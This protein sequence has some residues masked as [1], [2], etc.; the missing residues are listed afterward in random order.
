MNHFLSHTYIL[1]MIPTRFKLPS[2]RVHTQAFNERKTSNHRWK[3]CASTRET[4]G[5]G[6][7]SGLRLGDWGLRTGEGLYEINP[8]GFQ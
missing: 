3:P 4:G 5:R 2:T 6:V 8:P 7:K 1:L